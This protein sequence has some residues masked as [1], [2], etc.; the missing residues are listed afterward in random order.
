MKPILRLVPLLAVASVASFTHCSESPGASA[1]FHRPS[2]AP[3]GVETGTHWA[4]EADFPTLQGLGYRFVVTTL[5]NNRG[6][7]ETMF[8]A[9][10]AAGLKLIVGLNPSPYRFSNGS[11]TILAQ[12]VQFLQYAASRS[13]LVKAIF[14]F[15]EPYW[16]DPST[17]AN[18]ICGATPAA[19][20]R[21]LRTAIRGVWPGALVYHD[22][23]QPSAWAPGG[24]LR[25]RNPCIADKY[26]DATG[27]ADFVGIW[28]YPFDGGGYR[29]AEMLATLQTEI[30]Y[31]RS[32]MGAEPVSANQSF[33]CGHCSGEA[34]RWPTE[35]ELRD[36]NCAVRALG[37]HAISWYP[38]QQTLYDDYLANHPEMWNLTTAS[39]CP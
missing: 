36:Y 2:A 1:Q 18:N 39:A 16:V 15:N 4:T 30:A 38:W 24:T 26:A 11:W 12:G 20:L 28:F 13:P 14:V 23:G 29:R 22:I 5:P 6:R 34:T 35:S 21:S 27:V 32:Q 37:P 19:D 17:G 25:R 10:E 9:A 33:R 8:N 7:W 31:V 3:A